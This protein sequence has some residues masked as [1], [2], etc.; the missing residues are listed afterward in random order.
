MRAYSYVRFSTPGQARGRSEQRQLERSSEYCRRRGW[1]L[2]T[3][4]KVDRGVSAFTGKNAAQGALR[5]FLDR[6]D[7]GEIPTPCALV[8]ESVDRISRQGVDE[9]F[10]LLK[11]LISAGVIVVTLSP[12]REYDRKALKSLTGGLLELLVVLERA[13]EESR[14][15][16]E[17]VKD[18]YTRRRKT[19][20]ALTNRHP[21]WV[22]WDAGASRWELIPEHVA[23]VRRCSRRSPTDCRFGRLRQD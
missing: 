3:S 13:H 6:L 21:F 15:K 22:R 14:T 23:I 8:V 10:D 5:W 7:S 11:R 12:E 20:K 2:D 19:G 18:S 9:G 16:S 1:E 4:V 17:R